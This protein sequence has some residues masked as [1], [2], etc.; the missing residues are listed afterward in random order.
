MGRM[1]YA[2][3]YGCKMKQAPK[4][5]GDE[6]WWALAEEFPERASRPAADYNDEHQTHFL[7]FWVAAG[8]SGKQ[9]IPTLG[10]FPLDDL[11]IMPAYKKAH[12][13][14]VK[15]WA[16]FAAW[17]EKRGIKLDPPRLWLVQ[18]EVA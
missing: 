11:L 15:A 1:T 9:G 7:G 6:G 3:M 5:L 14:A 8:A 12:D 4:S 13:R 18:T 2:V 16:K 10:T 17:A